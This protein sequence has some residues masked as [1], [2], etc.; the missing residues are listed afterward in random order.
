MGKLRARDAMR[1]VSRILWMGAVIGR[2]WMGAV[3]GRGVLADCGCAQQRLVQ[4]W[5]AKSKLNTP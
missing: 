4:L 5:T 2:V 1:G 3:L